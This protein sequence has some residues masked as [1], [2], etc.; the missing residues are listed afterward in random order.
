MTKHDI[1]HR[2]LNPGI[3]AVIRADNSSQLLDAAK[4][5]AGGA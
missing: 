5:M 4:A 2:M 1:I 3:I